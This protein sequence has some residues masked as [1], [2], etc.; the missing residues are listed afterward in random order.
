MAG[1]SPTPP[2]DLSTRFTVSAA[3]LAAAFGVS[4]RFVRDHQAEI[5]H[6]WM[7]NRILFP[8]EQVREWLQEKAQTDL[9]AD[10]QLANDILAG[11]EN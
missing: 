8:V 3:E 9:A 4:E 1:K 6:V 2:P 5:P 7:G 11:L 10:K